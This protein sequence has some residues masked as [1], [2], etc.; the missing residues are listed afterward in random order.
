MDGTILHEWRADFAQ[1]FPEHPKFEGGKEP[2]RNFWRDARLFPNGD[3]IVIWELY[4]LFKLDRDSRVL[5][6]VPAPVHHD[7]QLTESGEIVHLQS[8]RK[9]IAGIAERQAIEDF[10]IVRDADGVELRRLAMSDAL[11]NVHWL[12]LRKTFWA[13]AKER[14]YGLHDKHIY[15]PFH[16]NSLWLLS[17]AEAAR[18]GDPFR[19]GDALVSM[20]MLDTIAVVD[21][22][23]AKIRWWQQGPFGMQ[24]QP[25]V[26]PDGKIVVFNN[27]HAPM[28]SAV[29]VFDP[30]NHKVTWEY[31][32]TDSEPL[33][34]KRSGGAQFLPNGNLL[35]VESDRGRV[36]EVRPDQRVVWEYRSPYRVGVG[37][38]RVA[39][40]PSMQRLAES[41]V[42]WLER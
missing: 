20:A 7:L 37:R 26:T 39:A 33:Y 30:R 8:E 9:M 16:T 35:I 6:V 15:D 14:G 12:R 22:R 38:D 10:I 5:W 24:H 17:S 42:A 4:G 34:S 28:R 18:I 11:R 27:Y 29:Q 40:I 23:T 36:I 2:R 3:I 25:R 19:A 32:G 21:P 1:L 41:E 31:T 13:R